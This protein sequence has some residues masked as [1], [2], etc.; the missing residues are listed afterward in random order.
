MYINLGKYHT[1]ST[2]FTL[3]FSPLCTLRDDAIFLGTYTMNSR[4]K[5]NKPGFNTKIFSV[6]NKDD[7]KDDVF[8]DLRPS[9]LLPFRPTSTWFY[10]C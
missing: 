10:S 3:I 5:V 7:S 6:S 4:D 8:L 1:L 9:V 2:L